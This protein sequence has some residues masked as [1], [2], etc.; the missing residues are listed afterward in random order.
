MLKKGAKLIRK[1]ADYKKFE[2]D[3]NKLNKQ[4]EIDFTRK[5]NNDEINVYNPNL[6]E[7]SKDEYNIE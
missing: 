5:Q 1:K 6:Y 3:F 4:N 2:R 7:E